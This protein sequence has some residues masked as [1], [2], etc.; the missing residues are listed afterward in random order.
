MISENFAKEYWHDARNALGK[1]IRVA[2]TDD[3]RE[4]VGVVGDV[5]DNGVDKPAG[6]SVYW[7]VMLD[8]FEGQKEDV[9]R[10]IG[11]AIRSPRA[12]SQAFLN[13]VRE[14]V[15][16]VDPNIPTRERTY[17]WIFLYAVHGADFFYFGDAGSGGRN[18]PAAGDR[19]NLWGD[20]VFGVAAHAGDRDS[21]GAGRAEEG[22][23]WECLCGRDYG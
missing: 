1:R 15:W 8:R 14:T 7:P 22:C 23:W 2:S 18:G 12:G 9:R 4:I 16:S 3:W 10:G 19:G 6:S 5:Y 17:A 20:C 21:H 13:E 11:F